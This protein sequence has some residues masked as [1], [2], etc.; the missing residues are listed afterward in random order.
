MGRGRL[1]R[2]PQRVLCP[3]KGRGVVG[4][5]RLLLVLVLVLVLPLFW[6]FRPQVRWELAGRRVGSGSAGGVRVRSGPD[7]LP[8]RRLRWRLLLVRLL[9][10]VVVLLRLPL[11]PLLDQ[12]D[13]VEQLVSHVDYGLLVRHRLPLELHGGA[14]ALQPQ[15]RPHRHTVSVEVGSTM[16]SGRHVG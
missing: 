7:L 11:L 2:G 6:V 16:E 4:G 12:L 3:C 10:L 8:W 9:R 15:A 1:L 13:D 5:P 14:K